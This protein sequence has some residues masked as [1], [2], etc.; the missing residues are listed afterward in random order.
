MMYGEGE[1]GDIW[2]NWRLLL[3]CVCVCVCLCVCMGHD[4]VV[5]QTLFLL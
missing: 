2:M 1:E 4:G 3:M 5:V